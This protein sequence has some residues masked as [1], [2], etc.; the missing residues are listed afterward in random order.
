MVSIQV[1]YV[2]NLYPGILQ[3]KAHLE[4]ALLCMAR[5]KTVGVTG[6]AR[7]Q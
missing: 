1:V 7:S 5:E 2:R 3:P 4:F 6:E